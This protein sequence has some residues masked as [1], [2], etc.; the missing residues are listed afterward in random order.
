MPLR[1]KSS[2]DTIRNWFAKDLQLPP[3]RCPTARSE[4]LKNSVKRIKRIGFGFWNFET[5]MFPAPAHAGR[6]NGRVAGPIVVR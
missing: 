5:K 3:G 2:A 1:W 6:P 4:A